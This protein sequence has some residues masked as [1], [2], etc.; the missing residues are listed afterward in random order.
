MINSV[1]KLKRKDGL[2]AVSI[3]KWTKEGTYFTNDEMILFLKKF[4]DR[5]GTFP[6]DWEIINYQLVQSSTSKI[7]K[8]ISLKSKIPF[9]QGI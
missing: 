5:E 1:V 9:I 4:F 2:F 7:N 6:D 3:T 8:F